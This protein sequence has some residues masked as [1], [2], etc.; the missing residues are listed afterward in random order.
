MCIR[1]SNGAT[2]ADYPPMS[3]QD[4]IDGM[5]GSQLYNFW[6][7]RMKSGVPYNHKEHVQFLSLIHI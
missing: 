4:E 3:T 6:R 1:D 2:L 5:D 7:H